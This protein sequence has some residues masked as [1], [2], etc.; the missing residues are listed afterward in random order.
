MSNVGDAELSP[1]MPEESVSLMLTAVALS[2]VATF[3]NGLL[4]VSYTHL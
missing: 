3:S 1:L 2:V 4:P